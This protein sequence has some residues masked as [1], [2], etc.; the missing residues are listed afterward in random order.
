MLS[1]T[2]PFR[3]KLMP[4]PLKLF[5]NTQS[6]CILSNSFYEASLTLLSKPGKDTSKKK[7]RESYRSLSISNID[8]KIF[9]N[10]LA[11]RI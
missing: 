8:V 7:K 11:S 10:V 1:P 4:K 6:E 9:S 5:H 3:K 2:K